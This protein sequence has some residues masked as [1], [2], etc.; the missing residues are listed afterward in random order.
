MRCDIAL[1]GQ[2]ACRAPFFHDSLASADRSAD[3]SARASQS[4]QSL[5]P[6]TTTYAAGGP[7]AT[8]LKRGRLTIPAPGGGFEP[9]N[10]L[11][12]GGRM[13]TV[14]SPPFENTLDRFGHIQP[15]PVQRG[16]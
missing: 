13:L 2:L 9:I 16:V 3:T 10:D 15:R 5:S 8:P 7:F 11:N 1:V 14:Q 6:L 12:G 4:L